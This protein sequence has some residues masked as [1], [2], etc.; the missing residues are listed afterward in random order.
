MSRC[1]SNWK[2]DTPAN[3]MKI[4]SNICLGFSLLSCGYVLAVIMTDRLTRECERVL[5]EL[6][7]VV[8]PCAVSAQGAMTTFHLQQ[9]AL[10]DAVVFGESEAADRAQNLIVELKSQLRRIS[11][12]SAMPDAR[13]KQAEAIEQSAGLFLQ[14]AIPCF[15]RLAKND[16]DPTL[17]G[18]AAQLTARTQLINRALLNLRDDL[19]RDLHTFIDERN[20][21]FARDRISNVI[22]CAFS[23]VIAVCILASTMYHFSQRLRRLLEANARLTAGDYD[24][25]IDTRGTDEVARLAQGFETMR[26]AVNSRDRSLKDFNSSLN[27]LVLERTSELENRNHDLLTQIHGRKY[28]EQSLYLLE[29]AMCQISHGVAIIPALESPSSVP[30]YIN[31]GFSRIAALTRETSLADGITALFA[32]NPPPVFLQAWASA[33]TGKPATCETSLIRPQASERFVEWHFAPLFN[34][35][36]SVPSI[37]VILQDLTERKYLEVQRQ[38]GQKMESVGQLAAGVAHEINTPIQFIGDNL[39]FLKDSFD[40][41]SRILEVHA[42]LLIQTRVLSV[43]H[44]EFNDIIATVDSTIQKADLEYLSHEMPKAIEQSLDGVSRVAEIVRAMKEFSHPDQAEKKPTDINKAIE[45]TLIVSRNE[46]KY[47]ASIVSDL[48]DDLPLVPC[49]AGEF[50]QVILN[51]IVNAA[52]AIGDVVEKKGGK[53]IIA[54]TSRNLE[55]AVEVRIRDSGTGIPES[56]RN[57]IFDPFFTTKAVGKGTGQGLFIAHSVIVK[58]HGGTFDFE[59]EIGCGTVFI[60]RLPHQSAPAVADP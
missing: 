19:N 17:V 41:V 30:S 5:V 48:A 49:I 39:R 10:Q 52:H 9:S 4:V 28:A 23:F 43:T 20:D 22:I 45:T 40:E 11:E 32:G 37:V 12:E 42:R 2:P 26:A 54:I 58:N 27:E 44:A 31:P 46:Y 3:V 57:K 29:S 18:Q 8:I 21:R 25:V 36:G 60:I 1:S 34:P 47:V 59:T 38:Q 16:P 33:L 55:H 7:A 6:E 51:V 50:N 13:R 15:T 35:D 56:A 53:G 24:A 14:D